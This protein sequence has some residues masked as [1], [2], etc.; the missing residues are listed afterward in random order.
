M[1]GFGVFG[2]HKAWPIYFGGA[3]L[4]I[5][6]STPVFFDTVPRLVLSPEGLAWRKRKKDALAFAPWADIV[7]ADI[8]DGGEDEPRTLVLRIA[9]PNWKFG[10]R[11]DYRVDIPVDGLE[12]SDRQ[13]MV[14]IHR[15]AP[16]LF[17]RISRRAL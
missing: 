13:L 10:E 9:R 8:K 2:D 6:V 15:R 12:L 11:S 1:I 7:S 3:A 14:A 5:L 4:L 16:H 17:T